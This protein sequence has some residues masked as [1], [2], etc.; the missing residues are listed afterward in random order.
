M[1]TLCILCIAISDLK[2]NFSPMIK[3]SLTST[4]LCVAL[5]FSGCSS[6]NQP[7]GRDIGILTGAIL[8]G[9]AGNQIGGG[10]DGNVVAGAVL[11]GVLGGLA[12]NQVDK[13]KES[14]EA[15]EAQ[16]QYEYE[17]EAEQQEK[18][19]GQIEALEQKKVRDQIARTATTSD[20]S[21]A[22]REAARV[23]AE[24]TAK[25]Q[26]YEASQARAK[27]IQE[28]QARIAKAQEELAELERMENGG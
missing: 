24:L 9:I 5:L 22:E 19:E 7:S 4:L 17:Q 16:R 26:A 11:G 1:Y 20:V 6:T 3:V 15:A 2:S 10:G 28:A 14:L 8:G 27:R 25:K 18:L 13:R 12:G 21:A 23:E